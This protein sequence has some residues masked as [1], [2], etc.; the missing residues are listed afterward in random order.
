MNWKKLFSITQV[1]L[2]AGLISSAFFYYRSN[3]YSKERYY[4]HVVYNEF[5]W[6]SLNDSNDLARRK[7]FS[8]MNISEIALDT[9]NIDIIHTEGKVRYFSRVLEPP[10]MVVVP[11]QWCGDEEVR[12]LFNSST[13]SQKFM[14]CYKANENTQDDYQMIVRSLRI[15]RDAFRLENVTIVLTYGSLVGSVRYHRRTPFDDDYDLV[16]RRS[17]QQR[18]ERIFYKL[19]LNSD[20]R[21]RILDLG[22]AGRCMQI[23]L[24]CPLNDSWRNPDFWKSF[25]NSL[26]FRD[27]IPVASN[28]DPYKDIIGVCGIFID[29]MPFDDN[30]VHFQTLEDGSVLYRP[31]EG[32]LF[33]TLSDPVAFLE[34]EYK[35]NIQIC[36]PKSLYLWQGKNCSLPKHC[37]NVTI[38]C[39]WL[40][41]VYPRVYS[42]SIPEIDGNFEV[43]LETSPEGACLVRS[44]FYSQG[45]T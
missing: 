32:T 38:P 9:P 21:M 41:S 34:S 35:S 8:L 44:I 5:K 14:E 16:F 1:V 31:I 4:L 13:V 11:R 22:P 6:N 25:N 28:W 30:D 23:G 18:A 19:A 39:A 7:I 10:D 37:N 33:R 42:F 27:G 17:D 45:M 36:I 15:I 12:K 43:G 40:D 20:N 24:A 3:E 26:T 29:I 2:V